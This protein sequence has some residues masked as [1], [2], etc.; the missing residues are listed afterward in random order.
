M[1]PVDWTANFH[2]HV[3]ADGA[4]SIEAAHHDGIANS[5]HIASDHGRT[6]S[7]V[8][9][10]KLT[11]SQEPG[12]SSVLVYPF[13]IVSTAALP[14]L[15]VYVSPSEKSIPTRPWLMRVTSRRAGRPLSLPV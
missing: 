14:A 1:R 4:V 5:S 10:P 6:H 13:F 3:E 12:K 2:G 11:P 7:G 15:A 9:L 8:R